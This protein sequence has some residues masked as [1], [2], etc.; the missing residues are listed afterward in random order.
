MIEGV[1]DDVHERI[2]QLLDHPLIEFS[3]LTAQNKIDLLVEL[4]RK[5]AHRARQ[6]RVDL[7]H[8]HQTH[9]HH[10][11]LHLVELAVE[12]AGDLGELEIYASVG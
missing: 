10:R 3:V 6:L 8:R 12:V 1:A 9:L 5:L 2:G 7:A 4:A 11:L